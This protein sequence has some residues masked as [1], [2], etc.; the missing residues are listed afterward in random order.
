MSGPDNS[1]DELLDDLL[2]AE[3]RSSGNDRLR[4]VVFART[5]GVIRFRRR[6]KRCALAASLLGCYLGGMATMG[7][8]RPSADGRP[9]LST[10]PVAT[11]PGPSSPPVASPL[12]GPAVSGDGQAGAE[13]MSCAEVLRRSGDR[14]LF[15]NGDVKLA[16]RNYEHF[17]NLPSAEQRA[18]SPGQD[19]WLLMALKDA[20]S[21]EMKHDRV[22]Q[23]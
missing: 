21:K 8:W 14:H 12:S 7:I 5:I 3:G 19:N 23:D 16:V 20:R 4:G 9:Q 6:L 2:G 17:L 1:R 11:S 13:T 15:E 18:I 22:E 10:G